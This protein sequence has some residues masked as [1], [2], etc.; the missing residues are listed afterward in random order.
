MIK[1]KNLLGIFYKDYSTPKSSTG[2]RQNTAVC[3]VHFC[4]SQSPGV[5]IVN[6]L[7]NKFALKLFY[8][9]TFRLEDK[10]RITFTIDFPNK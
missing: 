2:S 9:Y 7:Q 6:T 5:F 8:F 1:S 3:V 4:W 10:E